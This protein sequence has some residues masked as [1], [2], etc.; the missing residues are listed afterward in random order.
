MSNIALIIVVVVDPVAIIVALVV[1]GY[2][3]ARRRQTRRLR[4]QYGPRYDRA[5]EQADS[6]RAAESDLRDRAKRHD[7]LELRTLDSSERADFE[8]RWSDVQAPNS[9][10]TRA[11]PVRNADRLVVDV[12]SA[13]GYPVDDFSNGPTTYRYATP[14]SPSVIGRRGSPRRMTPARWTPKSCARRSRPAEH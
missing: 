7:E 2:Q 5:I 13:R 3:M 9:W 14:R 12:M 8:R 1:A 10:T 4:R 11:P 6:Q